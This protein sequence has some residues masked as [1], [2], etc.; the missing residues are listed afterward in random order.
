MN[1]RNGELPAVST[2][3][4]CPCLSPQTLQGQIRDLA[5]AVNVSD[6]AL[7]GGATLAEV[8]ERGSI[9]AN[10]DPKYTPAR[11]LPCCNNGLTLTMAG[12]I[13]QSHTSQPYCIAD[14]DVGNAPQAIYG[15][16]SLA[17]GAVAGSLVRGGA[18]QL[19]NCR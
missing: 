19:R 2:P 13:A 10:A 11:Y 4:T 6:E 8:W 1:V 17:K 3:E 9:G 7:F 18:P 15:R 16:I 12:L 14:S 5:F